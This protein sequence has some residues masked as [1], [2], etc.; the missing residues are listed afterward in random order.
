MMT[1]PFPVQL[2]GQHLHPSPLPSP[3]CNLGTFMSLLLDSEL[4]G[5]KVCTFWIS[6][7]LACDEKQHKLGN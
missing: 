5:N 6:V 3:N 1:I 7:V 2:Q 4:L